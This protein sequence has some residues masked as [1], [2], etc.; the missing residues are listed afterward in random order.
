MASTRKLVVEIV[1]DAKKFQG[2]TKDATKATKSFESDLTKIGNKLKTAFAVTAIAGAGAAFIKAGENAST[3]RARIDQI[4]K[5]MGRT[6]EAARS[7]TDR[8]V[9]LADA[10][11]RQTGID[12]NAIKLAQAKL[13][14]FKELAAS[15][16]IVGG[17]FDRATKA[18]LDLQASGFGDAATIAV[19]LGK[20]LQ[21]P[22]SGLTALRR[23]GVTFTAAQQGVIRSLVS[24]NQVAKAQDE[25]LKAVEEQVGGTAEATANA[26]DKMKVSFSQTAEKIGERLVPAMERVAELVATLSGPTGGLV[27]GT[28]GAVN[29]AILGL[30]AFIKFGFNPN[31][32][33]AYID[34][35]KD[36]ASPNYLADV[37]GA[38]M[39]GGD[40]MSQAT[41]DYVA[42]QERIRSEAAAT[43]AASNEAFQN[44]SQDLIAALYGTEPYL[45]R[46]E[47]LNQKWAD[48]AQAAADAINATTDAALAQGDAELAA[49]DAKDALDDLFTSYK[50]AVKSKD[51]EKI[52]DATR[53]FESG[54]TRA[55]K[56]AAEFAVQGLGPLATEADKARARN[57]ALVGTFADALKDIE[58]GS[59]LYVWIQSY[60]D[61][62]LGIPKD[63][64]TRI[65]IGTSAGVISGGGSSVGDVL[66]AIGQL[67]VGGPA[68]A[69][70]PYIVGEQGPELF[71]PNRSG[72][73]IPNGTPLG[74]G[75]VV[76]V[77]GNVM[78][79]R[80]LVDA[81][82]EGLIRK[83]RLTGDLALA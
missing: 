63:I 47:E 37:I 69:G 34:T 42:E 20:A 31:S 54:L 81:V 75:V 5:S 11:A 39:G 44:G 51:I 35:P 79:E 59:E 17:A 48:A 62:L 14:T 46:Q 16:D 25:I 15:A 24:T 71:V 10:T 80:N 65:N 6:D 23:S 26:T 50:D 56:T 68:M 76:N 32:G 58:P 77:Y 3:S 45:R 4:A 9:R 2:A 67:A 33:P 28:V 21:D 60:I 27:A 40:V 1:G 61:A 30:E 83:K 13:L 12:Q 18:S 72:T 43:I 53:D 7:L 19:Q 74:G 49:R 29:N 82:H 41:K 55:G 73:V 36:Y 66:G 78:T 8:L 52:D 22:I 64:Q 38:P 57:E 70:R